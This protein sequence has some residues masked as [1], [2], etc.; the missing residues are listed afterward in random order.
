[1]IAILGGLGAALMW[2]TATLCSSR[3]SRMLSSNTVL[4]WVMLFGL[5]I[6]LPFALAGGV[7][8]GLDRGV[9]G[10]LVL[11]GAA[12][13]AGL[14]L[15]Y[16]ALRIGKVG[17]VSPL[18]STEGAVAASLAVIAG[19]A[20]GIGTGVLLVVIVAGVVLASRPTDEREIEDP[21]P[22][23][24]SAL[25]LGAALTFGIGL[26]ASGRVSALVPAAWVILP[27]RVI[28]VGLVAVPMAARGRLA[29]TRQAAPL[30]VIAGI[31]EVAGFACYAIGARHGIAVTAVLA[32]QFAA[33]AAVGA[34]VLFRERLSALQRAGAVMVL[35]G[36]ALLTAVQAA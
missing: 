18:A 25:A 26:Y 1:V 34:Y 28:G 8:P 35:V 32:S 15:V 17:V 12:N 14:A 2:G 19:E 36:V 11:A 27:A 7:P 16:A 31:C 33:V 23:R 4:A 6:S 5:A 24:A 3:S 29:L 9:L 20:I 13:V 21:H 10:W 22:A 30:V